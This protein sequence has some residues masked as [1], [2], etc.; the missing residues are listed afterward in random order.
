[1]KHQYLHLDMFAERAV[2]E[3]IPRQAV[4]DLRCG[5]NHDL[6]WSAA[7]MLAARW[8]TKLGMT[9]DDVG[10]MVTLRVPASLGTTGEDAMRLRD[11]LL[12][13]DKIELQVHAGHGQIWVRISA[14]VYNAM[15]EYE[16]LGD[17]VRKRAE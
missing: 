2:G 5:H 15:D 17:V 6:A 10:T 16:R 13:E 12:F 14:Q 4:D 1:M 11:A 3:T 7:T 8:G 9:E